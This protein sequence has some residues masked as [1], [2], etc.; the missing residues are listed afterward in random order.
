[1]LHGP[2]HFPKTERFDRAFL[3]AR[4]TDGAT[5]LSNLDFG[6]DAG[7]LSEV[8]CQI[9]VRLPSTTTTD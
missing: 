5:G 7:R 2:M 8:C 1:M 9:C 6:H 4:L 3:D